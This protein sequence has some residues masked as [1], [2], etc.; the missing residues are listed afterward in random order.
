MQKR[1]NAQISEHEEIRRKLRKVVASLVVEESSFSDEIQ[2]LKAKR[3][4]GKRVLSIICF[5]LVDSLMEDDQ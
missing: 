3:G 1:T 2:K 4:K 5:A